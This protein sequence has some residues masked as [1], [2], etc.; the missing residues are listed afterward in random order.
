MKK[1]KL[2]LA[3][4]A[5]LK[6]DREKFELEIYRKC[7][8]WYDKGIFLHLDIWEDLS[9]RMSLTGSQAEYNKFVEAADVFLLLAYSKVGM[10]TAVE[11]E[12]AF[13][14]FKSTKKPFI[15]TYFKTDPA[16]PDASLDQF[17][18]KLHDLDHFISPFTDSNDLWN[19]FN[20]ELERLESENFA[21]N[22]KPQQSTRSIQQGDKSV[23]VEKAKT[24]T[25]NIQ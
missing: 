1:I 13:G 8:A 24:V 19:Q 15:F 5:E 21:E 7:K 6:P 20:K 16:S 14:Q 3:S 2:F 18:Q 12:K 17:K 4:S 25:L 23:Y 11:F 10:Y 22:K 9:A